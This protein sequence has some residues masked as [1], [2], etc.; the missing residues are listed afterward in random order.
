LC[1]PDSTMTAHRSFRSLMFD[2]AGIGFALLIALMAAGDAEAT[3][4][5]TGEVLFYSLLLGIAGCV[6]LWW[7]RRY[8]VGVALLLVPIVA[9]TETAG[10]A[11]LVAVYTVAANR[12][13]TLTLLIA[14]LHA[15]A[16]VPYTFLRPDA[17]LGVQGTNAL[18]VA[19]LAI[20]V[21]LGTVV[22]ARRESVAA[23]RERRVHAEAEARMEAERMRTQERER[24]AQEM[25]DVL[26][27][28]ISLVSLHAG[29]LEV[30]PDLSREE[31]A[32]TAGTI[33]ASAHQ[34]LEDLREILGVLR[35]GTGAEGLR[36]QP[37][38]A[39]LPELVAE[40]RS[41]GT[42]VEVDERLR[43]AAPPAS[44]SRT[45]YRI[46]QEGLTNARKHAPGA[47]VHVLL[48]RTDDAELHVRLT[49]GLTRGT[50][51]PG[52]RTGLVGLAERVRLTGGRLEHGVR[53]GAELAFHLEAW[54]PWVT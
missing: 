54:L 46:V 7:R 50:G 52:A 15:L 49:N 36:P 24:I 18:N 32:R 1:E 41:T 33:R 6:A 9:I 17:A 22:R 20:T 5:V 4:R 28:R 43:G 38:L 39:D 51:I 3:G 53:N 34:A 30:R 45:A 37:G 23:L 25:H 35:A 31:V 44:V 10:G 40:C 16:P 8:P 2:L 47:S 21:A 27:H 13:W 12:R 19:L 42:V 29:A 14:L 48:E 26:A 11:V